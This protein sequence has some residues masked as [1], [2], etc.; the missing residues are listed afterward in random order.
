MST[1]KSHE[2][3]MGQLGMSSFINTKCFHCEK[4]RWCWEAQAK[5]Y[6]IFTQYFPFLYLFWLHMST[7]V[8]IALFLSVM[9]CGATNF[10]A[11]SGILSFKWDPPIQKSFI[12][13]VLGIKTLY[14]I[15]FRV[16]GYFLFFKY[17]LPPP[18]KDM[19]FFGS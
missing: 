10:F 9:F 16:L 18:D 11:F 1:L 13:W 8:N 17:S 5:I 14:M 3:R 7:P 15:W 12:Q 6:P 4:D 2:E 19:C